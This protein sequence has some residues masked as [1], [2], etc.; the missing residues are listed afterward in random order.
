MPYGRREPI[1]CIENNRIF[2]TK[3]QA[4][5]CLGISISSVFDSLRDGKFHM[6]YT[7]TYVA[8]R[9]KFISKFAD[10]PV[11]IWKDVPNYEGMYQ[12]SSDGRVWSC[13]HTV[14]RCSG[15]PNIIRGRL[16]AHTITSFGYCNV[17]LSDVNHNQKRYGVHRLV[18]M[19]FI[20]NPENKPQV[21]HK[22]GNKLN[23]CVDN[24]EWVTGWE[25]QYHAVINGLTS[26][27]TPEHMQMMCECA[28]QKTAIPI[29]CLTNGKLY[30]S[31]N[32]AARDLHISTDTIRASLNDGLSHSGYVFVRWCND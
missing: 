28:K 7:F 9:S 8:D 6:G 12:V 27:W 18:A 32:E 29:K 3:A 11:G 16:L 20:P 10:R 13:E 17:T 22:D 30:S 2:D 5:N 26:A 25:N 15:H 23:N 1:V 4:A 21:N 19:A 31:Y 14:N 24:L